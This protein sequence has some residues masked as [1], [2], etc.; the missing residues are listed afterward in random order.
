MSA[1]SVAHVMKV[2]KR[3]GRIKLVSIALAGD[4]AASVEDF[5]A[6]LSAKLARRV[7]QNGRFK[8]CYIPGRHDWYILFEGTWPERELD[9]ALNSIATEL[10][11]KMYMDPAVPWAEITP[12]MRTFIPRIN[13]GR[14]RPT[15]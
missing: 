1:T 4:V 5:K 8:I 2:L 6:R 9:E 3:S 14:D 7:K 10:G 12:E 15:N 13:P 11:A